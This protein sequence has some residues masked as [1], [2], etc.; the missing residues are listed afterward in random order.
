MPLMPQAYELHVRPP[1]SYLK[2]FFVLLSAF[3]SIVLYNTLD[4]VK[5]FERH[6]NAEVRPSID[7]LKASKKP[8]GEACPSTHYGSGTAKTR[9]YRAG[10]DHECSA[11]D[12][13]VKRFPRGHEASFSLADEYAVDC[14]LTSVTDLENLQWGILNPPPSTTASMT[15]SATISTSSTQ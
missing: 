8:S 12:D 3:L 1:P 13:V 9:L 10:T 14:F 6:R 2:R 4:L 7:V 5:E 11:S 15:P